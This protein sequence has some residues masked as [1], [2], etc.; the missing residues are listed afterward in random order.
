MGFQDIG[1]GLVIQKSDKALGI[2]FAYHPFI[3]HERS[4]AEGRPI[5]Q[6]V[7][8]IEVRIP[9]SRDVLIRTVTDEDRM[10]HSRLYEHFKTVNSEIINGTPLTE[11][12][13]ITAAERKELEYFNVYTAEQ[14]V[15]MADNHFDKMRVN[16]RDMIKKVDAHLK[17]AKDTA[18]V[19]SVTQENE[20]L[21]REIDVLKGQMND[22]ISRMGNE[23]ERDA[24]KRKAA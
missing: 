16:C 17:N 14:L 10:Q 3:D 19:T 24:R 6:D 4:K 22:L 12:P 13:F 9:G 15:G 21:K 7:E 11:F 2:T 5:Y 23:D 1:Q 18:F 8:M 20:N